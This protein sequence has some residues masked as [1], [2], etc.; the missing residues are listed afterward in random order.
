[1]KD[2]LSENYKVIRDSYKYLAG[3]D[4]LNNLPSVGGLVLGQFF[5]QAGDFVDNKTIGLKDLDLAKAAVK[6]KDL[7]KTGNSNIPADRIVRY[8]FL[9]IFIRLC[10]TK[11]LDTKV[12]DNYT[13][14]CNSMFREYFIPYFSQLDSHIWRKHVLWKEA[15]DLALKRQ[16][17]TLRT[18]FEQWTGPNRTKKY[19]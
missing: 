11:Y 4:C 6:G 13:D 2:V 16:Y 1:M 19:I 17:K 7:K 15:N 14:A 9:E 5:A 8:N 10:K 3:Q 18:I 12:C